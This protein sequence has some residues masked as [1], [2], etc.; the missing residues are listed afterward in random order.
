MRSPISCNANKVYGLDA[1]DKFVRNPKL[2]HG[3]PKL[4]RERADVVVEVR[5]VSK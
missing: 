4:S 5:F 2:P 3:A 1:F